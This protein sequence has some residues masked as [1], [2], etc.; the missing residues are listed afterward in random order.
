MCERARD[1]QF[2]AGINLSWKHT[3]CV[4][5][6]E[7]CCCRSVPFLIRGKT[8]I[9]FQESPPVIGNIFVSIKGERK[10]FAFFIFCALR[11]TSSHLIC[12]VVISFFGSISWLMEIGLYKKTRRDTPR[13]GVEFYPL[14]KLFAD[15]ISYIFF[16]VSIPFRYQ[17]SAVMKKKCPH[18][19]FE[20]VYDVG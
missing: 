18:L 19:L 7:T 12:I 20:L 15:T 1:I 14:A 10:E 2:F 16:L 6:L 11:S 3:N 9:F 17:S 4:S 5:E 13:S 8:C